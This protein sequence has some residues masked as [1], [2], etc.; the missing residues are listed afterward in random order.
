[1]LYL[2]LTLTIKKMHL[3]Q[4]MVSLIEEVLTLQHISL[5]KL[6]LRIKIKDSLLRMVKH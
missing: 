3:L 4:I 1:M 5:F 6:A 2:N